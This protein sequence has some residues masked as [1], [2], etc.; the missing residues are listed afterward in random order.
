MTVLMKLVNGQHL[1]F[2]SFIFFVNVL[3]S[4]NVL[5]NVK[6]NK[7]FF[8]CI[9]HMVPSRLGE[10]ELLALVKHWAQRRAHPRQS[11]DSAGYFVVNINFIMGPMDNIHNARSELNAKITANQK[12]INIY[13]KKKIGFGR[14]KPRSGDSRSYFISY[15]SFFTFFFFF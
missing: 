8:L 13:I 11:C 10:S 9:S 3:F 15:P 4:L 1:H 14:M 5:N 7:T 6:C 12:R 2:P